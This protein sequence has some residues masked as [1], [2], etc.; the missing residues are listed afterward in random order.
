MNAASA[1]ISNWLGLVSGV[2]SSMTDAKSVDAQ[3]GAEKGMSALAAA[4]AGSNMIYESAGMTAALLGVSFEGFVLDNDML[5]NI[6]RV[7]R[8]VDI[9]SEN[10]GFETIVEAVHGDGHFLAHPQTMVSMERDYFYPETA[11][12]AT[13]IAWE[14]NGSKDAQSR[15]NEKVWRLLEEHPRYLTADVDAR[16]RAAFD[17]QLPRYG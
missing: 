1:Q 2:A 15:A 10:L 11:D 17:I 9:S 5:G 16:I 3:Y 12:R 13:P 4:L 7:L 14:K 6:Y 8:G